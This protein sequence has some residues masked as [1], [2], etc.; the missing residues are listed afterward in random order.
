MPQEPPPPKVFISY[1][2]SP[3][4]HAERV[5]SIANRLASD[6]VDVEMDLWSVREGHDLNAFMERMA[7]DRSVMKVLIFSN[8][9]YAQKAD[10]RSRGVGVEAQIL[11]SE[12]YGKIDQEKFVPIVCEYDTSGVACLP[13]FLKGRLYVDFSSAESE[14]ENYERL[15]RL[16]F[17]KPE[18]T[19]PDIGRP[20]AYITADTVV[21]SPLA[22]KLR[23]YRDA[24]FG[25]K[26]N[27]RFLLED[28]IERFI[29][30]LFEH[31]I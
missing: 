19:K 29:E 30:A 1:S 24:L 21:S 11:S 20:P 9:S 2:H 18:H 7:T 8:H 22:S 12:I 10:A 16:I 31:K 15:V 3:T 14:A 4:D 13:T 17:D 26:S 5:R 23:S 6:G 25:G 27:T 28:F